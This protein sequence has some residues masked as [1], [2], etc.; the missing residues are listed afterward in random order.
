VRVLEQVR[1]RLARMSSLRHPTT[2]WPSGSATSR[3]RAEADE[4]ARVATLFTPDVVTVYSP[5]ATWP[6]VKR[7]LQGASLVVY[8]GHGN[9][10]PS[11]HRDS[12]FPKTQNGFGLNPVAGAGDSRHQYFGE[13]YI[14]DRIRLADDAVVLLHHLCYASG[15]SEPGR[16]EGTIDEARQR[17]DNFA[18][19]FIRAG[20][21]AVIAEAHAGPAY[22]VGRILGTDR[23]LERIWRSA[24]TANDNVSGFPSSRSP[25]FVARMDPER[26]SSGF[27]RSIVLR[28]G[29]AS[30]DV[31]AGATT[32][33]RGGTLGPIVP[34]LVASG[35]RLGT[36]SIGGLTPA[37]AESRV[38][39]PV[40]LARGGR[41]PETIL[42]SARWVAL[43]RVPGTDAPDP[44]PL[45]PFGLVIPE[46]PGDVVAPVPVA[47][48]DGGLQ[49]PVTLPATPGTYR[50]TLTLHD[51]DGV[52][53][54]PETQA[55]VPALIVQVLG[56]DAAAIL[57]PTEMS[58]EPGEMMRVPARIANLGGVPWGGPAVT[59]GPDPESH[60]PAT[61]AV[62][63]ARWVAL[64]PTDAAVTT[65]PL[66]AMLP[67]GLASG[68][69]A[70]VTVF[71]T[72]PAAEG[73][74]LLVLDIVTPE[75]GSLAAVGVAPTI[76]TVDI[77]IVP[78]T[79]APPPVRD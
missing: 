37:G 3:Y 39:I 66:A 17:I 50:L 68:E 52:A 78:P 49:M 57:A 79:V 67:P 59:I 47:A 23:P 46:R 53:Y 33:S 19:G 30:G 25:D 28:A 42:A 76:V 63:V 71:L 1:A 54:D 65:A 15:L 29:L 75:R 9:G 70:E 51:A 60:S 72:A 44:G 55:L 18:A 56:D 32:S 73:T 64:G 36:P 16:P 43:D 2:A 34:S 12:P 77:R 48:S 13:A 38:T 26:S 21:A 62:V 40:E 27:T 10:W 24:P 31:R 22:L 7:A 6:A 20:A 14:G 45:D 41:L 61:F 74:Y 5:N 11:H 35:V 8:I 4:A 58:V 69:V